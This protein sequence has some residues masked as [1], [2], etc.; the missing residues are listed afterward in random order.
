MIVSQTGTFIARIPVRLLCESIIIRRALDML[1]VKSP[2]S[3]APPRISPLWTR[4]YARWSS[5]AQL[6]GSRISTA[7]TLNVMRRLA[8]SQI[9]RM[10]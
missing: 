6:P 7:M 9:G 3:P 1:M 10:R 8:G 5:S 4:T 2:A